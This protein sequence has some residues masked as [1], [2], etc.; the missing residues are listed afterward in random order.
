MWLPAPMYEAL[1]LLYV[2]AGSLLIAGVAYIGF[3]VRP[4]LFYF[5]LGVSCIS[6]GLFIYYIRHAHRTRKNGK[7]GSPPE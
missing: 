7:P 6:F 5:A 2:S 4:A 1:P 3:D